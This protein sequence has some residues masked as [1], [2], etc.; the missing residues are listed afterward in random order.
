MLDI[1][2]VEIKFAK[3][4]ITQF[5]IIIPDM[6]NYTVDTAHIGNFTIEKDYENYL[7]PYLEF[8]VQVPQ[9]IYSAILANAENV[10]VQLKVEYG[11]YEDM[12]EMD[13][14][15]ALYNLGTIMEGKFY[16]F[17]SD[18]SPRLTDTTYGETVLD[19]LNADLASQDSSSQYDYDEVKSLGLLL[20]RSDHI[21]NT[22]Q[23]V[24]TVLNNATVTDAIIYYCNQLGITD[25][26]MSPAQ[27][28]TVYDQLILPPIKA[29]SG[30]LRLFTTYGVHTAGTQ[31]FFDYDFV[32]ILDKALGCTA[33]INNETVTTY[34]A[35]FPTSSETTTM[36]SGFY[37]NGKE[38]Y[39]YI[40]IVGNQISVSNES[41]FTDQLFGT[42]MVVIDSNTGEVQ[43]TIASV[44]AATDSPTNNGTV[45]QV[46]ILDSGDAGVSAAAASIEQS[47]LTMTIMI[48]EVNIRALS[49]NKDFIFTTD[50]TNYLDL[51]GHY[52]ITK[53]VTEFTKESTMFTCTTSATF[54]GGGDGHS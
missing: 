38:K 39:S 21:L 29:I 15:D 33:W 52:R 35:S 24:N 2:D 22:N 4:Q 31:L 9:T 36:R 49:P 28:A 19:D 18:K 50:N 25:V 54:V 53:A 40:P 8:R 32:Y 26:L 45:N 44:T 20:Y 6:D 47:Q 17:L 16:A 48:N 12:Y 7:F 34:L 27:N 23:V 14:S 37:P 41:M 11:L 42:N 3:Y 30:L 51:C 13:P 5:D 1:T 43:E 10:Y 46:L